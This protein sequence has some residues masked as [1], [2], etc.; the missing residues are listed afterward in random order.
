MA[1]MDLFMRG[2]TVA[3]LTREERAGLDHAVSDRQRLPA[4]VNLL[5]RGQHLSRSTMLL[6]GFMVRYID[7][8]EGGRQVVSFH[9]PGDFV[10]LHGFPIGVLDHSIATV[11]DVLIAHVP[12]SALERLTNAH[13]ALARKLWAA[14]LL[15]AA[16]HREWL[17]TFG[18]L[19]A[20]GRVAHFFAETN[21]RLR[22]VGLSDGRS[23]RLPITQTD[24][25]EIT[26][27]TSI[28]ANRV[29]KQLREQGICTFRS[30]RVEIADLE[31][32]ERLAHFD[33]AYLYLDGPAAEPMSVSI[34]GSG[35]A[36]G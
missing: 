20:T 1:N 23:Y 31:R 9:V 3:E 24:L 26:G 8:M 6:E 35:V 34:A 22:V 15:D 32:L 30:S 25:A 33:A 11:S 21:A 16:M 10:D 12:H 7:D 27:L 28:H 18:R 36:H 14:T 4:R 5:E 19:D 13:P 17:F 2:R 29:L